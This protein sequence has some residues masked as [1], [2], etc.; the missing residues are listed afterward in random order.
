ML[1][2]LV[3]DVCHADTIGFGCMSCW[4]NWFWM[5]VMLIQLVWDVCHADTIGFGCVSCWYNWFWMCVMLIQLV[6]DVCH[7]DTI[8]FGCVSCWYNWF[9]MC[10]MLIQL[11]LDVCHADTTVSV[12][13]S[14]LRL[15]WSGLV[16]GG[17]PHA[18]LWQRS[19]QAQR[20]PLCETDTDQWTHPPHS[21]RQEPPHHRGWVRFR[22]YKSKILINDTQCI[23]ISSYIGTGNITREKIQWLFNILFFMMHNVAQWSENWPDV[24]LV[25]DRSWYRDKFWYRANFVFLLTVFP[26]F[27]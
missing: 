25:R 1:I 18:A 20:T 6:L 10:V 16:R 3:W 2:Q 14:V 22:N 9:W 26:I 15:A 19:G 24:D 27:T 7:A 12:C 11:V 23:F 4:Y 21:T 5:Y 13:W 17:F 8:G